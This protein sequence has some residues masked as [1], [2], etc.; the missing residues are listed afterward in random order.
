VHIWWLHIITNSITTICLN[1]NNQA[2]DRHRHNSK[3]YHS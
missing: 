3:E 1:H 2:K